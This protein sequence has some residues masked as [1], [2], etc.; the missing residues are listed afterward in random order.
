MKIILFILAFFLIASVQSQR[1]PPVRM[2]RPTFR[3]PRLRYTFAEPIYRKLDIKKLLN[4]PGRIIVF[5]LA[6][7]HR[8]LGLRCAPLS[9]R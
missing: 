2:I 1:R 5:H 8:C 4:F 7:K 3:G 6:I 9:V